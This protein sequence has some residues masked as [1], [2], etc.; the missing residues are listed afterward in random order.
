MFKPQQLKVAKE[1][2]FREVN[3]RDINSKDSNS[4]DSNSKDSNFKKI[5]SKDKEIN[6]NDKAD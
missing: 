6:H 1:I 2:N 5:V 4:K 3:S